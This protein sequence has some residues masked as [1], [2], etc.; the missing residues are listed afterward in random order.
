MIKNAAFLTIFLTIALTSASCKGAQKPVAPNVKEWA[1]C[2]V[3]LDEATKAYVEAV[4]EKAETMDPEAPLTPEICESILST[5]LALVKLGQKCVDQGNQLLSIGTH[6]DKTVA[7]INKDT[8]IVV[9][10]YIDLMREQLKVC[11]PLSEST[12]EPTN[13]PHPHPQP[14]PATPTF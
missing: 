9:K 3:I 13:A 12:Q 11:G 2:I 1:V 10:T 4:K 14:L 8:E 6:D 7:K 5:E